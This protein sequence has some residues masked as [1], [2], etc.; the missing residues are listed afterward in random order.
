MPEMDGFS[1]LERLHET[2]AL[3]N[4]PVLVVS[5]GGLTNEQQQ[6]LNAFGQRLITKGSLNEVQLIET[7]ENALKRLGP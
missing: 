5:G 2:P 1:L 3:C 4:I 6:Q 7:I